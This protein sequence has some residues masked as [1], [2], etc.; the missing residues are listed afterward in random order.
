MLCGGK[1]FARLFLPHVLT[2]DKDDSKSARQGQ[3]LRQGMLCE[4][5][6]P[7]GL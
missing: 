4:K 5:E 1:S 3:Q 2:I 7:V 6:C